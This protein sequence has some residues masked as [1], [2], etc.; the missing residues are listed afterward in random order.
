MQ[1]RSVALKSKTQLSLLKIY[2]NNPYA[3]TKEVKQHSNENTQNPCKSG[4]ATGL[5]FT[6][7]QHNPDCQMTSWLHIF[8]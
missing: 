4:Q 3:D 7:M 6:D 1:Q 8:R 5:H 2:L